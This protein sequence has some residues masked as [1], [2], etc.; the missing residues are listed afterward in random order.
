[1]LEYLHWRRP[2]CPLPEIYMCAVHSVVVYCVFLYWCQITHNYV[3]F[4]KRQKYLAKSFGHFPFTWY[5]APNRVPYDLPHSLQMNLPFFSIIFVSHLDESVR[6]WAVSSFTSKCSAIK[7]NRTVSS[8]IDGFLAISSLR[9][10]SF[11]W[12][13]NDSF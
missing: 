6:V 12:I 11:S 1:M 4:D 5:L 2:F 7:F 10:S 3:S 9:Y 8:F 13:K